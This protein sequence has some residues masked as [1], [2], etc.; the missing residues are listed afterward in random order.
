MQRAT[1]RLGYEHII[2]A[3][4]RVILDNAP[5]LCDVA[6]LEI[7]FHDT[8]RLGV[9]PREK[10]ERA[11]DKLFVESSALMPRLPLDEID[12]LIVVQRKTSNAE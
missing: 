11:E 4:A 5:I 8:A 9:V 3:M 12:L 6:I 2:R 7:Q 1:S 10:I